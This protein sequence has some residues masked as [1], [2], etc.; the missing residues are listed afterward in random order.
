M[1]ESRICSDSIVMF[2]QQRHLKM[3][4]LRDS[5]LRSASA[6]RSSRHTHHISSVIYLVS[7]SAS[8]GVLLLRARHSTRA[9][10]SR[11]SPPPRTTRDLL[12]ILACHP[13][14]SR[15]TSLALFL[16]IQLCL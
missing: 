8:P 15:V 4:D 10:S 13:E 1:D 7:H 6:V 2:L 12:L 14:R 16:R 9:S 5:S 11:A 3:D